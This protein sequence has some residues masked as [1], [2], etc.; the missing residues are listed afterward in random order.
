[1]QGER[2]GP[3][4]IDRELGSGAMGTVYEAHDEDGN[5]VAVKLVHPHLIS[6]AG[7]VERFLREAQIGQQI[8]HPNVVRLPSATLVLQNMMWI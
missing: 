3:Y 8:D 6:T 7:F 5:R 1:M 2:L 4:L